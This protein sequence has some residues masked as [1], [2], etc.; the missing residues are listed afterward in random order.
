MSRRTYR[1][2]LNANIINGWDLV[3][4]F[5]SQFRARPC[6]GVDARRAWHLPLSKGRST[7]NDKE[8]RSI[9]IT[10]GDSE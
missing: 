10:E 1:G 9:P 2:P 7:R 6:V 4:A 3:V 5:H 8:P